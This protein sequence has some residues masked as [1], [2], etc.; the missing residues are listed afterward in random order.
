[1]SDADL[2]ENASAVRQE[3]AAMPAPERLARRLEA[4]VT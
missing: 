4:F 2:R 3:M 1:V